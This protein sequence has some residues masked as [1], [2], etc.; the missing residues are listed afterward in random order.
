MSVTR[1][2]LKTKRSKHILK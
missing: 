2:L 1:V